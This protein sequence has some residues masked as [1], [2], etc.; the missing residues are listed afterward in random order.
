MAGDSMATLMQDVGVD[1]GGADVRVPQQ[2]LGGANVRASLQEMSGKAVPGR[3]RTDPF[4]DSRL[5]DG[6]G[7]GLASI[8]N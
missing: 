5:A 3:M 1:H 6:L 4:A 8:P 2:G 7:N